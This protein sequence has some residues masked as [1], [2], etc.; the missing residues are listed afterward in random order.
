MF[1]ANLRFVDA[2]A[3]VDAIAPASFAK[4]EEPAFAPISSDAFFASSAF[5][6]VS[7][8]LTTPEEQE[9]SRGWGAAFLSIFVCDRKSLRR[10]RRRLS[11]TTTYATIVEDGGIP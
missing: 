1:G 2:M 6:V 5:D 4:S 9:D 8:F 10:M 7:S 3:L 11:T